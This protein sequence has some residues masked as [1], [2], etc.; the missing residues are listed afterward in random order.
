MFFPMYEMVGN[1]AGEAQ[2]FLEMQE[3]ERNLYEGQKEIMQVS[4][5]DRVLERVSACESRKRQQAQ[6][7]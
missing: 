7:K 4:P 3:V 5:R 6:E 2:E 1:V